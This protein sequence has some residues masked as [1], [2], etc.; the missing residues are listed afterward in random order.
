MEKLTDTKR[1]SNQMVLSLLNSYGKTINANV[2]TRKFPNQTLST[3]FK[4]LKWKNALR[5][6]L[7][8]LKSDKLK[9]ET[10]L[11]SLIK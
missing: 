4:R 11:L 9:L 10:I 2:M 7:P 1:A 8:N 6:T 5:N 3:I